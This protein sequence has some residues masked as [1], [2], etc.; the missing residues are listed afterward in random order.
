MSRYL[1]TGKEPIEFTSETLLVEYIFLIFHMRC[2]AIEKRNNV[3][4]TRLINEIILENVLY[5]KA[6]LILDGIPVDI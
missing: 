6:R 4:G 1:L 5:W 2:L 3:I